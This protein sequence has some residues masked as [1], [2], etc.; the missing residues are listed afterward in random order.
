M[1]ILSLRLKNINSLR[2]EWKIDFQSEPFTNTGLFAITGPTGA[3]KTT[4]LDAICLALYHQT[5]RLTTIS[6][7]DNELMTRHTAESLAEVEFEVKG[8]AYRAFWSQRRAR[9]KAD[10]KL[11]A[12]QVELADSD[13]TII[14][15]RI[16]DKLKKVSEL[17]GL[18]FGRF[19]K[20]MMLAQGGFAAFLE[21]SA[22]DRAELLEELTGTEIYGEISRR[23]F[24][25]M[26]TSEQQLDLLKARAG[27]IAL[28]N[29]D[30]LTE[31]REEQSQLAGQQEET[32]NERLSLNQ[33]KRWLEELASRECEQ[34]KARESLDNALQHK[35]AHS[36]Q[37]NRLEQ[38]LPAM[39]LLPDWDRLSELTQKHQRIQKA[40]ADHQQEKQVTTEQAESVQKQCQIQLNA[41]ESYQQEQEQTESLLVEQVIPLDA[42]IQRLTNEQQ[43]I[44]GKL[45]AAEHEQGTLNNSIADDQH[46]REQL[47]G[48]LQVANRYLEQNAHQQTLGEQL[49]VLQTLFEQRETASQG[50]QQFAQAIHQLEQERQNLGAQHQT[51]EEYIQ[52]LAKTREQRA[53]QNKT[54][55]EN[56]TALLN[57]QE[58]EQLLTDQ[59]QWHD[60]YPIWLH[61]NNLS[62][63]F[64]NCTADLQ[65]EQT[66]HGNL[67]QSV[68]QYTDNIEKC[69]TEYRNVRQHC[70]DLEQ[71]L[72]R[73]RQI[74]SLKGYR[75]Q[76]H[77][78]AACPLCGATEHPAIEHYQQLNI[79][80]TEQR[81]TARQRELEQ[82]QLQGEKLN[83]EAARLQVQLESS[84]QTISKLQNQIAQVTSDWSATSNAQSLSL[85]INN[86]EEYQSH[87]K[88][89]SETGETQK[90]QLDQLSQLN[91]HI[92]LEQQ[93]LDQLNNDMTQHTHQREVNQQQ[94][95]QI[96]QQLS[97]KRQQLE[98]SQQANR[99]LE[100][101]IRQ[102]I[103]TALHLEIPILSEQS[104]WLSQQEKNW[105][106]W[107]HITAEQQTL[108]EKIQAITQQL[109]HKHQNRQKADELIRDIQQTLDHTNARRQQQQQQ[110]QDLFGQKIV[111]EERQRLKS[112]VVE[113]KAHHQQS[114]SQ[115]KAIDDKL[116]QLTGIVRQQTME[117]ETLGEA[118][119]AAGTT[120]Q[121][122]L[123][124]SPFRDSEH[125]Q[126]ALLD[127]EERKTLTELKQTIEQQLHEAKGKLASAE[128]NLKAHIEQ[129]AT[130][131]TL[132]EVTDRLTE[133]DN[134]IRLINQR[135]G[136]I[137]QALKDD[138]EKRLGQASLFRDIAT[139]EHQYQV[140]A[141]LSGLIGSSKGDKFRKFAQG[142]TLDH[143]ILL[144]NRQLE[145]LHARYLLNRKSNDELSL[146]VLDTWQGDSAR[147][148]KTL[149]GGESFLVSL[150]LALGLSDLVSHKTRIDSLFLDEGFGTLDQETLETALSALDSLNASGKMVGIISHIESLKERIPTRI[151]VIKE[152][153]LGYSKLG[154]RF[155]CI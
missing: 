41:W 22:N 63:Q 71:L 56:K 105:Q 89:F 17:T 99:A 42:D 114:Q 120:W 48:Q 73:E 135:Q 131:L 143:L 23:A 90:K 117:Q 35:S 139:Q 1:K 38:A 109:N 10:G 101:K 102:R 80:D 142:L 134:R 92:Q 128:A 96:D 127:R 138:D 39:E 20:S 132:D 85:S 86:T 4:L 137:T 146:E 58:E 26:R 98:Q 66:L 9:G 57:G 78:G 52:S 112:L 62:Q 124:D 50:E 76:L 122:L 133:L 103:Q 91:R 113:A 148:I 136:E 15:T 118:L 21:A 65:K 100:E 5:P 153:G 145:Q 154:R 95:R 84:E 108:N 121:T 149:S 119:T 79:S 19:T 126:Q 64:A 49:P 51:L 140:W 25:R 33:Q 7:S 3:G 14:T 77:A 12:P 81:L 116:A 82:L 31:L 67:Q 130:K 151:E 45:Q 70:H 43:T 115:L 37:I 30:R 59:Q 60:Q 8:Q 54:L 97:E 152:T 75:N 11:Q 29:D 83:K 61:L 123:N 68:A 2:G 129:P 87:F 13:G 93:Q 125:F 16:S 55:L 69:R 72:A 110:R 44:K 147:D 144:A 94:Q 27:G 53:S 74:T 24:E 106:Q 40:L 28:L 36:E 46:S 18:D 155:A 34:K 32:G 47:T 111:G 88:Q 150:A 6:A 141:Q 107:Q 104:T